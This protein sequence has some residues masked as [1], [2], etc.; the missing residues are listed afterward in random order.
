MGVGRDW[1]RAP[2]PPSL[3]SSP[4]VEAGGVYPSTDI[5]W[6]GLYPSFCHPI[7]GLFSLEPWVLVGQTGLICWM[8]KGSR[9]RG[10][11][12]WPKLHMA[13][14]RSWVPFLL[15]SPSTQGLLS[16]PGGSSNSLL[17]QIEKLRPRSLK[18]GFF[19][20]VLSASQPCAG[21]RPRSSEAQL[22]TLSLNLS[23]VAVFS[24]SPVLK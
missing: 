23:E 15:P 19:F 3:P 12:V 17:L 6:R 11:G 24:L 18:K 8:R 2:W 14:H 22:S 20:Q 21:I 1:G 13:G 9:R 7:L 4:R 5:S 10:L 16:Q